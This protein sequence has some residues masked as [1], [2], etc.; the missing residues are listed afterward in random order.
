MDPDNNPI[1][2]F[3]RYLEGDDSS[4]S[5]FS[6]RSPGILDF[7]QQPLDESF[8]AYDAAIFED[9]STDFFGMSSTLCEDEQP[10][11]GSSKV[12]SNL[13]LPWRSPLKASPRLPLGPNDRD[14]R[15]GGSGRTPEQSCLHRLSFG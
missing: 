12:S 13:P 4:A 5:L 9:F 7:V 11:A 1:Y 10:Q 14:T 6:E 15:H 2:D 3:L 8:L